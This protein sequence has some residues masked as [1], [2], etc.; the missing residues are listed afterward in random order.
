MRSVLMILAV[1]TALASGGATC[2]E[3]RV[4][5]ADNGAV[6]V[7]GQ[8][9]LPIFVW[10][11]PMDRI[12]FH[13]DLGVN[14]LHLGSTDDTTRE[15]LDTLHARGMLALLNL[16]RMSEE[17]VGHPAILAWTV[18]H[19]MDSPR[20]PPYAADRSG[21]VSMI[22]IEGEQ[23]KR[24]SFKDEGWLKLQHAQL[25]GGQWL[26]STEAD[27]G[28]AVY[29]FTVD[30]PGAYNLWVREFYKPRANPTTWKLDDGPQQQTPRSLGIQESRGVGS[31]RAVGW[32]KYG[33]V[34]LSK[35][36][37]TLSLRVTPGRTMGGADRTPDDK[38][39]LWAVDVIC[40]TKAEN[41]PPAVN[42]DPVPR[43]SPGL[44]KQNYEAVK[45]ADPNALTWGIFSGAIG[46]G[47][48]VPDEVYQEFMKWMDVA[49][50][51]L[52]PVTGYNKPQYIPLVPQATARLVDWSRP[53]QPVWVCVE[54]SKQN[55]SWTPKDTPGPTPAQMRAQIWSCIAS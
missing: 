28:E 6:L 45:Q 17:V 40:L 32:G 21:D 52:Y 37:H 44:A 39:V 42:A 36:T 12:D 49:A 43:S 29:Q 31:S 47:K 54:S 50:F 8:P 14:V 1:T 38:T 24:H 48:R 33:E 26:V 46:R 23:P 34:E 30:Q 19:E 3:P 10:A 7:D 4:K 53:G 51:D 11:Q 25:S 41:F 20:D 18:N 2:A 9:L 15:V 13:R 35:G 55:L 27:K 22:W 5:L 16:D